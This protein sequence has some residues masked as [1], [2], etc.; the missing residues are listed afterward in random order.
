MASQ[1]RPHRAGDRKNHCSVQGQLGE[2]I[3]HRLAPVFI[4][5][6]PTCG[7]HFL[8]RVTCIKYGT[9]REKKIIFQE[10]PFK[11][12]SLTV[13]YGT[14]RSVTSSWVW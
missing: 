2:G 14:G 11:V 4:R 8:Y 5:M 3:L 1:H 13:R 10:N 7:E 12:E 9:Y 6:V